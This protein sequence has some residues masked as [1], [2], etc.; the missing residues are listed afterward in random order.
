M[1]LRRWESHVEKTK[2]IYTPNKINELPFLLLISFEMESY[3]IKYGIRAPKPQI[4]IWSNKMKLRSDHKDPI[5]TCEPKE[6][7][8]WKSLLSCWKSQ[9][10]KTSLR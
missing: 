1:L 2:K 8:F 4:D 5:K 6:L 9:V 7:S 10:T 3:I